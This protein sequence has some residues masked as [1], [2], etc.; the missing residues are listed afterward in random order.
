MAEEG[1]ATSLVPIE[2]INPSPFQIRT[3][4]KDVTEL[5]ESV[6]KHGIIEPLVVRKVKDAFELVVGDR[7][8]RAA[9]IVELHMVPIVIR[10]LSDEEAFQIQSAENVHRKDLSEQEKTKLVTFYAEHFKKKPNEIAEKLG[11]SYSWVVKYL[12]D[13]Y[14]DQEMHVM[15]V[16]SAESAVARRATNMT[17]LPK[18][19]RCSVRSSSVKP[20]QINGKPHNLCDKCSQHAKLHPEEVVS[21]FRFLEQVKQG[22]VPPKL[23]ASSKPT[24]TW[25]QRL[26]Q[27]SPEHSEMQDYITQKLMDAGVRPVITDR[28]VCLEGTKPDQELPSLNAFLYLD[29]EEVHRN[30]QDKDQYLR[31]KLE[32]HTQKRVVSVTFKGKSDREK[33]RVWNEVCSKLGITVKTLET[34][35]EA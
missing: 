27:R 14:K 13:K 31:G 7:R 10:E 29:G 33:Q 1:F 25:E 26:A 21:H 12:P 8:L 6:K 15:G 2:S 4:T 35:K 30:K 9:K 20:E 24:E 17:Q 16:K 19:E 32:K 18:C 5:V 34:Q 28:W 3:E 23:T 11:M 22:K